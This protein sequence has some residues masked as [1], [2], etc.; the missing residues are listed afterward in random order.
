MAPP[1][2][3]T[4]AIALVLS[5]CLLQGVNGYAATDTI[6]WGG[7]NSRTGYQDNH[8]MDPDIVGSAQFGQLFKTKLPGNYNNLGPE[9]TFAQPLVFTLAK[10]NKQYVYILTN[11][12]NLYQLEAKTGVIVNQRSLHLPFLTSDLDGCV[13]I[14]PTVGVTGT[15]VIDPATETMYFTSKTYKAGYSQGR[16]NGEYWFHAV[17]LNTLQDRPGYPV[18]MEGV[19][20]RN[21]PNRMFLSGNQHQRPG[22]LDTGK[23]VYAGFASHCVQYNFTGAI[24]GWEKTTGRLVEAFA[25]EGGNEKNTIPGGGVWMSGGG[26]A[27]EA[28]SMYFATGN[29]YASQLKGTPVQGRTPP[30]ALEEA[31]V[32]A[33]INDD[34]TITPIDFFMPWEKT[35]LDGADKDLGTSP[36]Q[37]LPSSK[38]SCPNVKRIGIVTGKSGKTYWLNLDNL[39]GYQMGPNQFDNVPQQFLN[40]N[41]VY[42]GAGVMPL[43]DGYVYINVIKYKT[44]I[45]KFGCDDKG[46]VAF[47]RAG[48]TRESNANILGVGH[49]TTTSLNGR[50][51]S[52]L[53]W[54][55][56]VE[57]LN[58]RIYK[59]I[60]ESGS[61]TMINSFNVP[62]SMKFGRPVFGDG[63]CY[64]AS[65]Q[66]YIYGFGSPV[67]LPLNCTSP[68]DFGSVNLGDQS[69]AQ[70]VSCTANVQTQ[71]TSVDLLGNPNFVFSGVPQLPL[72]VAQGNSFTFQATFA[73][74]QAG[75]LSSSALVNTTNSQAGFAINTPVKLIGTGISK[76][77]LLLVSPN[78]VSFSGVIT[79][80]MTDGVNQSAIL[81]NQGSSTLTISSLLF[82][83]EGETGPWIQPNGTSASVKSVGPFTFYNLPTTIAP[84]TSAYIPINFNPQVN[85]NSKVFMQVNSNGGNGVLDVLGTSSTQPKVMI[86]FQSVDGQTWVNYTS[87]VPFTFGDVVEANTLTRKM[88]LTNVGGP[89]AAALSITVSKP[90]YGVPGIVGAVNNVD[91]GEGT[92]LKAGESATADLYCAV[93]RSQVNVDSYNGTAQWT[94]NTGDPNMGKQYIQFFCNAVSEQLGPVAS[95]GSALYRYTG[96]AQD[97]TP[98]RQLPKLI[99]T[100]GN[101]NT[102]GKCINACAAAGYTLAGTQYTSECWCGNTMPSVFVSEAQ[103]SYRCTG[104]VAQTCGGNGE[105]HQGGQYMSVFATTGAA[106]STGNPGNPNNPPP[107]V[108]PGAPVQP[109]RIGNYT[110]AGCYSEATQGRALTGKTQAVDTNT[111]NTCATFC[112]GFKYF[113]S[114]Y[115]REC[116]CGNTLNAGSTMTG[117]AQSDCNTGCAANSTQICGAGNRLSMYIYNPDGNYTAPSSSA[118]STQ[119]ITTTSP[120]AVG[121]TPTGPSVVQRAGNFAYSRCVT[122]ANGMRALTGK[123]YADDKLTVDMCASICA[124]FPMMGVE[125]GRECYCGTS[126]NVGSVNAT[127]SDCSML[128]GGN[129]FQYCGAGNRINLYTLAPS[130]TSSSMISSST[131]SVSSTSSSASLSATTSSAS[132]STSTSSVTSSAT[133]SSVSSS[134]SSASLTASSSAS[135]SATSSSASSTITSSASLSTSSSAS[136]SISSSDS[137]S[138]SSSASSSSASASLSTSSSASSASSSASS[139]ISSSASSSD[140]SSAS[141]SSS[142][143]SSA[144]VSST[145]SATSSLSSSS[146]SLS[147]SSASSTD[148]VASTSSTAA[149]TSSSV[150]ASTSSS[151]VAST[152]SSDIASTSSSA[153]ASTSSSAVASTSSTVPVTTSSSTSDSPSSTVATSSTSTSTGPSVPTVS[154]YVY[155]GC[156][157]EPSG[158]RALPDKFFA[159]DSMTLDSCAANCT[160]YA[161]FGVE[162]GRECYCG[163]TR[164]DGATK[165][166]GTTINGACAMPCPGNKDQTCGDGSKL[167][168]FYSSDPTKYNGPPTI[169]G[170]NV[171]YTYYGCV[172]EPKYT[173]TLSGGQIASRSMTVPQ[174]LTWAASKGYKYAGVEYSSE[175]WGGNTIDSGATNQTDGKCSMLCS[176]NQR[177]YCG[178]PSL[179]SLYITNSTLI[180]PGTSS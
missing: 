124:G 110:F 27:Y 8:N 35:D 88:R 93:P 7:D 141:S 126:T 20:F 108:N 134:S 10:D 45:W 56:D 157:Q 63:I 125:Y 169:V 102:N 2:L 115:G 153:V 70:T 118:A 30:T 91:L 6:T 55:S 23:Y 121:P 18:S 41:S 48:D 83:V 61:L 97:N 152:S 29:G 50:Q 166:S 51:G 58:L 130:S 37:L 95:N 103:C 150:V 104:N 147:S 154:G 13:D 96:C 163:A 89:N 170:G 144:S 159:Y 3:F 127:E 173:R 33:K 64:V 25:M 9:S 19:I 15:G 47:T 16:L 42:A 131:S 39:G 68:S 62:G 180:W 174:C 114:E 75:P 156:Y 81:Q 94:L 165:T 11:Q 164:D 32:N 53:L 12:N 117:I 178:G 129:K 60:P 138:S 148:S 52:G 77:P 24:L 171:N 59:A 100:D 40:E 67:N 38:F 65:N 120:T 172:Q 44:H 99:Y 133:V 71:V 14:N 112:S 155:Q 160:D 122:E 78:T 135:L 82:S 107:V 92:V 66:G 98:G 161:Y 76:A 175:C 85:G 54:T 90:P 17:D 136:A 149:T 72:T 168:L 36:L 4:W 74:K 106:P 80:Q 177:T 113:G 46:N 22:L 179:L 132:I 28:G 176:G 167:S 43:E 86:E 105:F 101:A 84:Q 87:G 123:A 21:N 26:L 111:L 158:R 73:P 49:G 119:P 34:G 145:S 116:Y 146:A 162:Y 140:S 143:S 79:G 139:T 109:Q 137:F 69:A 5:S 128:C 31:A 142:V 57:G 151:A 1:S